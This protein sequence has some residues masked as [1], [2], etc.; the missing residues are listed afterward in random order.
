M[1]FCSSWLNTNWI[2]PNRML[3]VFCTNLYMWLGSIQRWT[4]SYTRIGNMLYWVW[5]QNK[6]N[7][8]S[9]ND[10]M[11]IIQQQSVWGKLDEKWNIWERSKRQQSTEQGA[12]DLNLLLPEVEVWKFFGVTHHHMWQTEQQNT[13]CQKQHKWPVMNMTGSYPSWSTFLRYCNIWHFY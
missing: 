9:S 4:N 7:T 8:L 10:T 2:S 6:R 12:S 5:D 11:G 13:Q 3:L 1:A